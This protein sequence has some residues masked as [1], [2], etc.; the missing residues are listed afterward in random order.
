VVKAG[1]K[2]AHYFGSLDG[3]LKANLKQIVDA[4]VGSWHVP[5]GGVTLDSAMSVAAVVHILATSAADVTGA[6]EEAIALGGDTDTTAA[7]VGGILG[8]RSEDS[9]ESIPWL[10][11]LSFPDGYDLEMVAR[12]LSAIRRG[13]QSG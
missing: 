4:S 7:I 8:C 1:V 11:T 13:R 12:Q 5:S 3:S 9:A 6:M 10:Q 2:E